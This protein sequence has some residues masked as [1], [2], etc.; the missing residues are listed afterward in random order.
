MKKHLLALAVSSAS[1]AAFAQAEVTTL[2]MKKAAVLEEYTGVNCQ[3]CPDGHDRAETLKDALG[4]QM[5]ILN[6][7]AGGFAN[8]GPGDIDFRTEW[9]EALVSQAQV[10]GYPAGSVNRRLFP[11][12]PPQ[13]NG[14]A[15][16]RGSWASMAP[17]VVAEGSPINL[18][19]KSTYDES[20]RTV[21]V[22][23]AG[24]ITDDQDVSTNFLNVAFLENGIIGN[25]IDSRVGGNVPDY[26]HNKV[27]RDFLTGQWGDEITL[28]AAGETFE[29]TYTYEVP[30]EF[31]IENC[32]IAVFITETRENV[33]T[34]SKVPAI[35]GEFD[36]TTVINP[37]KI[38]VDNPY[39]SSANG[40]ETS[41]DFTLN[42]YL[43]GDREFSATLNSNIPA[44]WSVILTQDGQEVNPSSG[45]QYDLTLNGEV[46]F[47]V[48]FVPGATPFIGEA[49]IS[50]VS[51]DYP[52]GSIES[53]V[54]YA[55]HDVN[56]LVVSNDNGGTATSTQFAD[57]FID[58]VK[59]AGQSN[60]AGSN[61]NVFVDLYDNG[62]LDDITT[63]Y[64]NVGFVSPAFGSEAAD[65]LE[66]MYE[67]GVD[68]LITGQDAGWSA[69]GAQSP[70]L[71]E[72]RSLMSTF[73]VS[74]RSD[75]SAARNSIDFDN[76]AEQLSSVETSTINPVYGANNLYPDE[77]TT[78]AGRPFNRTFATYNDDKTAGVYGFDEEVEDP[79]KFI[80]LGIGAEMLDQEVQEQFMVAAYD[81]LHSGVTVG[82]ENLDAQIAVYP[83]PTSDFLRIQAKQAGTA[84][85][86]DINGKVVFNGQVNPGVTSVD[87]NN[88]ANGT[89]TVIVN[90]DAGSTTEN[91]T[92]Q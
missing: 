71:P 58:G 76:D 19:V 28:P 27:F 64:Y 86:T 45:N 7:H 13:I 75:G 87:V 2:P 54:F 65:L 85:I 40:G 83:N 9:G 8:P 33:L 80:W 6:I 15:V 30:E 34:G 90:T 4:V 84:I 3:F 16:G 37:G 5:I 59:A 92:I 12:V 91:V 50:F 74:Y 51:A 81:Y 25:Q 61:Q 82:F 62:M 67:N 26:E 11:G 72:E 43:D 56:E 24:Y 63:V 39:V 17:T 77:I 32:D 20:T 53:P 44:D 31:V 38:D 18:G 46:A 70:G 48:E 88:F 35:D 36:G 57:I 55:V 89:Y 1:I 52:D 73:G 68:I 10:A 14:T 69:Y 42:S 79:T 21:T 23:V 22:D 29:R 66:T 60:V 41:I 47:A 49:Q 78:M